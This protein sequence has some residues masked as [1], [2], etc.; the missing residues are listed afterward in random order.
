MSQAKPFIISLA[1]KGPDG[2]RFACEWE[3]SPIG[4]LDTS[5]AS[6]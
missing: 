3:T 5:L 2:R 6:F 1:V 4:R